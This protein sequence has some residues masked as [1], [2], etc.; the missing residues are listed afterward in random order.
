MRKNLILAIGLLLMIGLFF[1]AGSAQAGGWATVTLSELPTVVVA[2]RPFTVEFSVRGHGQ[3]LVAGMDSEVTAVHNASGTREN[4]PA[5][6]AGEEGFY[7]ATLTLP[8]S[9][10][11]R[12][13][14]ST[15]GT[16]YRMPPLMVSEVAAVASVG[17]GEGTAVAWQL[18]LG[19]TAATGAVLCLF[20][21]TRQR[22]RL[23]LAGVVLLGVVSLASFGL[24]TQ[25]PQAVLAENETAVVPAI[26]PEA[27]GE[28]LFVAKGCIQCHTND[29]VTMAQN[30]LPFGPNITFVKR[31]PE[32]LQAW[33][34]D[35]SALKTGTQMPNLHLSE[36]EIDTL[37]AFLQT[38][39]D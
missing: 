26:A 2:E 12:W 24:Y 22:N 7:T 30:M 28:A 4:V 38:N 10:E 16:T 14:I 35:P 21:W 15:Y 8:E 13:E 11:W 17:S 34:A 27:M 18:I 31:S 32:Y 37:V 1:W 5:K 9:G 23:R 25:M 19:W 29:N 39:A 36:A 20:F 6:D 3:T 33:L